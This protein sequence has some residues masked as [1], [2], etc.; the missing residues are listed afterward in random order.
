[1]DFSQ[2]AE[3]I[4]RIPILHERPLMIT[5]YKTEVSFYLSTTIHYIHLIVG[6]VRRR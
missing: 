2:L 4:P 1:M 6:E 3:L 5:I